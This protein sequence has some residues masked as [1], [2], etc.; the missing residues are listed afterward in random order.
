MLTVKPKYYFRPKVSISKGVGLF[1]YNLSLHFT[2]TK[3][4]LFQNDREFSI[5]LFLCKLALMASFKV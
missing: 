2:L 4:T 5:L 3:Y 1:H